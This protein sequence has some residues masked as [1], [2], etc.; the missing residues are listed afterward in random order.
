MSLMQDYAGLWYDGIMRIRWVC[1]AITGGK[2]MAKFPALYAIRQ[3]DLIYSA[4][5]SMIQ[6]T[7]V[8]YR[9][10][11]KMD[12]GW[13]YVYPGIFINSPEWSVFTWNIG[14]NLNISE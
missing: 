4:E 2:L 12:I 8:K 6:Q 7:R 14:G 1:N 10:T 13:F 5:M 3:L 9:N 11:D